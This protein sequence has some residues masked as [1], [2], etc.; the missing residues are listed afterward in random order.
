VNDRCILLTQWR[1][2]KT[3]VKVVWKPKI[4]SVVWVLCFG[5]L[6]FAP[7]DEWNWVRQGESTFKCAEG[8]KALR[9]M[10]HRHLE[11][12]IYIDTSA[13]KEVVTS[14]NGARFAQSEGSWVGQ[15]LVRPRAQRD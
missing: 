6:S 8:I 5:V 1:A 9:G 2:A 13:S 11:H 12:L 7:E 3:D 10:K 14:G 4:H 15:C